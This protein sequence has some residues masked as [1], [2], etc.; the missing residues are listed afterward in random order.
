MHEILLKL[1]D[2]LKEANIITLGCDIVFWVNLDLTFLHSFRCCSIKVYQLKV[3]FVFNLQ[4]VNGFSNETNPENLHGFSFTS[5]M[6]IMKDFS[7]ISVTRVVLGYV[8]MVS[9]A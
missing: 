7:N 4:V 2:N 8:L 9:A 5:L 6:D 1:T 3:V